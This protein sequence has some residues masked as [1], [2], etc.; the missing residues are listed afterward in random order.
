LNILRL[1]EKKAKPSSESF[2]DE[3]I[4]EMLKNLLCQSEDSPIILEMCMGLLD[5]KLS[6][7]FNDGTVILFWLFTMRAVATD[8]PALHQLKQLFMK[9]SNCL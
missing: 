9:F 1:L 3:A 2:V 7:R 4:I 5:F 8:N 6:Q